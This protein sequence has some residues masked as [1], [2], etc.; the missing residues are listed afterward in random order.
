ML[1]VTSLFPF[2]LIC[3]CQTE[4]VGVGVCVG[5]CVCIGHCDYINTCACNYIHA[6]NYIKVIYVIIYP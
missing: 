5:T 6:Y 3:R 2:A 1:Q 4:D